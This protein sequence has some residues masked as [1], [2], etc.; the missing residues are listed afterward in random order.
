MTQQNG[1]AKM[2]TNGE[3]NNEL[4]AHCDKRSITTSDDL[5]DIGDN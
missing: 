2:E 4:E 5:D 1:L 3:I